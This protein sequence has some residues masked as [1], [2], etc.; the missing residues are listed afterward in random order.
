M[1]ETSNKHPRVNLAW[2][3]VPLVA[4]LLGGWFV[5]Q[6]F[7]PRGV[8]T[9]EGLALISGSTVERVVLNE[10]IQQVNLGLTEDYTHQGTGVEDPT[11]NLGRSVYFSY[12]YTQTKDILDAVQAAAP[13]K[14]WNAVRPQ[15][16]A[17]GAMAQLVVPLLILLVAF[18]F[19]MN[20]LSGSRMMGGFTQSRVKE[21]NQERPDVTFADVAGED[22]AVE[23]LEEIREF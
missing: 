7:Q 2:A 11:A 19:L 14:G 18:Y 6:A 1:N 12:S 21:F 3:V 9:S 10:G 20:R 17:L 5:W 22:E 15:G 23:E 4:L 8:D 16:S 13:A